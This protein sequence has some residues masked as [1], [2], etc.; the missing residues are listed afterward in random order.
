MTSST[1][2]CGVGGIGRGKSP[3]GGPASLVSRMKTATAAITIFVLV[4]LLAMACGGHPMPAAN[5]QAPPGP[6]STST[7]LPTPE[8]SNPTPR[9]TPK[10]PE[11][12]PPP[13]PEPTYLPLENPIFGELY[14]LRSSFTGDGDPVVKDIHIRT[15][16]SPPQYFLAV[17]LQPGITCTSV[18][19]Q[20]WDQPRFG[21]IIVDSPDCNPDGQETERLFPLPGVE[22][23]QLVQAM[24]NTIE[25]S[26][27]AGKMACEYY[28]YGNCP[29]GCVR[30]CISSNCN[31]SP[32][33]S[34]ICTS[35]CG[36]PG[37]CR[38][39]ETEGGGRMGN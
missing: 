13:T 27:T 22:E 24:V 9:P 38:C 20:A 32:D 36:G 28:R 26:L 10:P 5:S 30:T 35:D 6:A 17:V 15:E 21:L 34:G 37:S 16:G 39:P 3:R 11:P 4:G 1:F 18:E 8:P 23:G 7:P 33:G 2:G 29:R 25:E 14:R 19:G 31:I 12:T